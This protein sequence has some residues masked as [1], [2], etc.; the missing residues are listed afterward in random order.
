[1]KTKEKKK[2]H[3]IAVS[4]IEDADKIYVEERR[5]FIA[6]QLLDCKDIILNELNSSNYVL[7]IYY[8]G[9]KA[10]Q[11]T[12][13]EDAVNYFE[14]CLLL[15]PKSNAAIS[16]ALLWKTKLELAECLFLCKRIEEAEIIFDELSKER[17]NSDDLVLLKSRFI[18]LYMYSGDYKKGIS[19]SFDVLEHLDFKIKTNNIGLRIIIEISKCRMYLTNKLMI[20]KYVPSITDSRIL[21]IQSTLIRMSAMANLVDENLFA[22]L[23]LKLSNLSARNGNSNFSAPAFSAYTYILLH[24]LGEKNMAYKLAENVKTM[25][26]DAKDIKCMTNFI[27]SAFI[28]HWYGPCSEITKQLTDT[29]EIGVR[30]G[31]FQYAGYSFTALIEMQYVM[32][33]PIEA[34]NNTFKLINQYDKRLKHDITKSTVFILQN[35]LDI[36]TN[37][38]AEELDEMC[39]AGLDDSQKLTHY[40]FKMQRM[41][42]EN[43]IEDCYKMVCKIEPMSGLFKGFITEVDLLFFMIMVRLEMHC[44]LNG[45]AKMKNHIK[46]KKSG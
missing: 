38:N 22:L 44:L 16:N 32:G 37:S 34:L 29:I 2:H 8:A 33:M 17:T 3:Q 6:S 45:A 21:D 4:L 15:M 42:F 13:I 43:K 23:I 19:H 46:S 41:Y 40:Y 1:M 36:L 25:M 5:I 28:D 31:E 10:K 39:V 27:L 30:G 24:F 7:E 11:M 18:L 35:H 20:F 9:I 26:T 12:L 14:L